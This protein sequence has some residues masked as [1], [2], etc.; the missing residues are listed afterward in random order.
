MLEGFGR[1]GASASAFQHRGGKARQARA[2]RWGQTHDRR[3]V[4][5]SA[6]R[7]F[8]IYTAVGSGIGFGRDVCST[9]VKRW[10]WIGEIL[11]RAIKSPRSGPRC[12]P[13]RSML[14]TFTVWEICIRRRGSCAPL[15]RTP[16]REGCGACGSTGY[17]SIRREEARQISHSGMP[18]LSP[19]AGSLTFSDGGRFS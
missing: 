2:R 14:M 16:V 19:H 10:P 9:A 7:P 3:A 13:P 15:L 12:A 1:H 5:T 11:A 8:G 6:W 4:K 18:C 17:R